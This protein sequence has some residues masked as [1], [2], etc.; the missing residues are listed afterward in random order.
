MT[1]EQKMILGNDWG[2]L[3]FPYTFNDAIEHHCK[4]SYK[5]TE[6][7]SLASMGRYWHFIKN[8]RYLSIESDTIL[9]EQ[10][11]NET[12][13]TITFAGLGVES[14]DIK[15]AS[16]SQRIILEQSRFANMMVGNVEMFFSDPILEVNLN[17]HNG[18]A[19]P[20]TLKTEI[21]LYTEPEIDYQALYLS[22]INVFHR[23]GEGV[24]NVFFQHAHEL[25]DLVEIE[26]YAILD[27][28][29]EQLMARY[30]V[31]KGIFFKSINGLAFGSYAYRVIQY[32]KAERV[33]ET[34]IIPFRLDSP[35]YG[36]R[37]FISNFR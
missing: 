24:L 35:D 19:D 4:Y 36:G 11:I 1:D 9:I 13:I 25:V 7:K 21:K 28:K 15:R 32:S 20:L 2:F 12:M 10:L 37:P 27:N 22:R 31:E 29:T 33:I 8:S 17:F 30:Q 26:L 34:E 5:E 18:L 14:I 3:A 6:L 23:L 16:G